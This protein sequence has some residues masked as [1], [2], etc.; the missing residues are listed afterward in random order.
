M[1]ARIF[2]LTILL[3][4]T[5]PAIRAKVCGADAMDLPL[6]FVKSHCVE[7]HGRETKE[8]GLD[9][10][11]LAPSLHDAQ[12]RA[13]WINVYDRV[14]KNEM[15]PAPQQLPFA[16]RSQLLQTLEPLLHDA[17]LADVL[18]NGRGP[19]RRL[20]RDEFEQNL[21]DLL[22]L[23]DLNIRDMLPEDR[24]GHH[25]NKTTAM[26][27]LSRVQL[28]AFL[29]A[30]E[31]ALSQA[32]AS[33][34]MPPPA[35][36]L[37]LLATQM[38]QEAETFGNRE[39]MF[40]AKNNQLHSLNGG[41]LA[42]LRRT[43]QHDPDV[44][45]AIFRS[46]H[47]PYYGYPHGFVA[48]LPGRYKVRFSARAVLQQPGFQLLPAKKP[49]P[50]TFRARKPSG[51]DVS[52]DVR[53]TGGIM[54]IAP[55]TSIY[56]TTIL[57]KPTETFE[58]SL[59]GLPVPLARN[60]NNGPPEYRY[61][62]LP[63]GGQPGVAFQWLEIEGP[64]SSTEW[65]PASHRIL[66]DELPMTASAP[67][68]RFPISVITQTPEGDAPRLLRR[69][70]DRATRQ[71]LEDADLEPFQQLILS[72]L[73]RGDNFTEAMLAGYQAFLCSSHSLFVIEPISSDSSRQHFAI[74]NR[75]SHFLTN[76]APDKLLISKAA[77]KLLLSKSELQTETERL[78][79]APAFERFIANFTDYW[80]NLRHIYRDE[81]DSRLYPEYRFDNYLAESMERETREYITVLFRE[82]LPSA[83]LVTS[84]FVLANDRLADHYKLAP[85][86]GS[87]LRRTTLPPDSPYG[88]LLTQ[89]AILKVTANGTNASPV[90]RGAW[91]MDRILGDPPPAPPASVP[92]VEPDIR[93]AKTIRELLKQHTEIATCASCHAK[94]DPVGLALE[95]FDVM[96]A[97]RDRYR[98]LEQGEAITGIDRAGHDFRYSLAS[99]VDASGQLLDGQPFH[100]VRELK[101]IFAENPRQLARNL[102]QQ[103]TVYATGTPVRF[104]DRR[105]VEKILDACS[106]RQYPIRD[107]FI[108]FIQSRIF[109]GSET[110]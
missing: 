25:F 57:L 106:A 21:R 41:E 32:T 99:T 49:V 47:W 48:S 20:N 101:R 70:I 43:N 66:F 4:T 19:M 105:E 13:L 44:E 11:T 109:C 58:Y 50:M 23:P 95:N 100:D 15:P 26:L 91:L 51:P 33:G 108:T 77:Q 2:S 87:Q 68:S 17:D 88:G 80:L 92:A 103:W 27:D 64:L 104:S 28:I 74:A 53:A 42:E 67:G 7:C 9:L 72:R 76:S 60:V 71:P 29:D 79:A 3:L 98:V 38:F 81:P 75:S 14:R 90:V 107:L 16:Q 102:I 40:Y 39:A 86:N 56:E 65:P 84:D 22:Q 45:L 97:W 93:S 10:T 24:V 73:N 34:T 96:G 55:E 5:V 110:R 6:E 46:A 30:T 85:L 89:G 94:F 82:N 52:G 59:L 1:T 35:S 31:S 37:R 12:Q 83:T 78:I 62:P 8:G 63:V 36:K 61:P 54:D 69:F 18:A